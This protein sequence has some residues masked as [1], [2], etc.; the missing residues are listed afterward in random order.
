MKLIINDQSGFEFQKKGQEFF[1]NGQKTDFN[2]IEYE[3]CAYNIIKDHKVHNV[4][5]IAFDRKEKTIMLKINNKICSIQY[6]DHLDEMLEAL[7]ME[8]SLKSGITTL[9]APMPGLIKQI[10]VEEGQHVEKGTPLMVLEAM[11]MENIIKASGD[12]AIH[13]IHVSEK[14]VVEKNK[15]LITF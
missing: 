13:Q 4:Q 14:D 6:K 15:L 8:D 1:L 7:G 9:K 2:R 11:K 10:L 5:V 3:Y 12:G